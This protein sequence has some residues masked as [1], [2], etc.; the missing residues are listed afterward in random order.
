MSEPLRPS[1]L[2]EILDRTVQIYRSRFLVFFGIAAVPTAIVVVFA[3]AAFLFYA[4]FGSSGASGTTSNPNPAAAVLVGLAFIAIAFVAVP[5]FF[6]I[7]ALASAALNHA[8]ARAYFGEKTTI[9]DAYRAIWARGWRYIWLY[10]LEVLIVAAAPLAVWFVV[11]LISAGGLALTQAAGMGLAGNVLVVVLT[12]LIVLALIAYCIWMALRLSLAF[13]ACVVE[14][15]AAWPALKRSTLLSKGTRGRI[16]LLYLLGGILN[17]LLSMIITMPVFITLAFLPGAKDPQNEQF[18]GM[19]IIFVAYAAAFAVQALTKPVYGIALVLFYYDQRIRQ[20][21][22]DIEWLMHRAGLVV[23]QIAGR[24]EA[25]GRETERLKTEGRGT[26]RL[27]TA[28]GETE[29]GGGFNP[30]I[31]PKESAWASAP[32]PGSPPISAS[33]SNSSPANPP[34]PGEPA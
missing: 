12:V 2:G 5:M 21:G 27:G 34:Q 4:W 33:T 29:G 20:E 22:F 25:E 9:R 13:P 10:L 1:T 11:I 6:A 17:Y 8:A 26:E 30:R 15:T 18:A 28:A 23:P 24:L 7:T 32:E 3:S 19:L 16:F 31:E 14:Q